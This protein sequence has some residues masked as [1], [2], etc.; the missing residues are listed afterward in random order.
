ME[1]RNLLTAVTK[2]HQ[3]GTKRSAEQP[4]EKLPAPAFG[5]SRQ[6]LSKNVSHGLNNILLD[7]APA[8]TA[9]DTD[10]YLDV[11]MP[12]RLA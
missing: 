10:V 12:D 1:F 5:I 3:R 4:P 2:A 7:G 9:N 6:L 8:D 11:V